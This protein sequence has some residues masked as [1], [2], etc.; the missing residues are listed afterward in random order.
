MAMT[1][2]TSQASRRL[3]SLHPDVAKT[4]TTVAFYKT[5]LG[6]ISFD[7]YNYVTKRSQFEDFRSFSIPCWRNE[8]KEKGGMGDTF[9]LKWD[10]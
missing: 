8:E 10:V 4:L 9:L 3:P 2:P 7:L 6:S 5:V 1:N